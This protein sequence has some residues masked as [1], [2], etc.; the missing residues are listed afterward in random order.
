MLQI[1]LT[2]HAGVEHTLDLSD[3][4][5]IEEA[6]QEID[7]AI[8]SGIPGLLLSDEGGEH[9]IDPKE[10]CKIVLGGDACL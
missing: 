10:Y 2:T 4:Y 1:C 3:E 6:Q 5:S 8:E 7:A 9:S